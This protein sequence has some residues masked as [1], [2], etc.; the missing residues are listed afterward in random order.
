MVVVVVAIMIKL[1]MRMDGM[2]L[3]PCV[4]RCVTVSSKKSKRRMYSCMHVFGHSL[5]HSIQFNSILLL[6]YIVAPEVG[7]GQNYNE[8]CDIFSFTILLWEIM[9]LE[10]PYGAISPE[11]LQEQVWLNHRRPC[12][13]SG[14]SN[15]SHKEPNNNNKLKRLLLGLPS[16]LPR[17][18]APRRKEQQQQQGMIQ[19]KQQEPKRQRR[20]QQPWASTPLQILMRRGWSPNPDERPRMKH[21]E[22]ILRKECISFRNGDDSGLEHNQRRSTHV[23]HRSKTARTL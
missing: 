4:E 7:L 6:G 9:A 5:A 13:D 20:R 17:M 2:P 23:F 3:R 19:P 21:V 15:H 12:L 18:A 22:A 8:G 1:R 16:I 14:G 10:R 11:E